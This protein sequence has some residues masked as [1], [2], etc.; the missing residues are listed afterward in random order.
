M[1]LLLAIERAREVNTSDQ[2]L[3]RVK[4]VVL[5]GSMLTDQPLVGDVDLAVLLAIRAGD[6]E[7]QRADEEDFIKRAK[8]RGMS[9][10][11]SIEQLAYPQTVV[12]KHLKARSRILRTRKNITP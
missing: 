6:T 10:S 11:T 8:A 7:M 1:V 3:Y 9:F 4:R 2:Y 5:F 12:W